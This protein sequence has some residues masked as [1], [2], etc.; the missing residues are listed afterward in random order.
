VAGIAD[1]DFD[2]DMA[3]TKEEK[4]NAMRAKTSKVWRT[5]RLASRTKFG[6]LDKIEDGKN[7][8]ALFENSQ[9]P[10]EQLKAD[11]PVG[12]PQT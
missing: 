8:R 6:Q 9:P 3:K 2:I 1:D 4:E 7:I 10:E 5:L 12:L 11:N